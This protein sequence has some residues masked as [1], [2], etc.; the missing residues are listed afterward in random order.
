MSVSA[1]VLRIFPK[2]EDIEFAFFCIC[3]FFVDTEFAF[4]RRVEET[5]ILSDDDISILIPIL[6]IYV[7][8]IGQFRSVA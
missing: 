1:S 2:V 6:N 8:F 7:N 5:A 4:S 3:I